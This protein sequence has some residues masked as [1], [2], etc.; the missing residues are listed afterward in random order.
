MIPWG[1]I[2]QIVSELAYQQFALLVVAATA[3][4]LN[5]AFNAESMGERVGEGK[6]KRAGKLKKM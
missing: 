4:L 6:E 1:E 5:P 2:A 3:I